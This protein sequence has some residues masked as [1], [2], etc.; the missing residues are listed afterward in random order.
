MASLKDYALKAFINTVDH[1]GSMSYKV[2]CLLNEKS[3]E[4]SSIEL[5]FSCFEQVV[6][7][8]NFQFH[9]L[10]LVVCLLSILVFLI[11]ET[12]KLKPKGDMLSV[13]AQ[14]TH[15]YFSLGGSET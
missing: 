10:L 15:T 13:E 4:F 12:E 9:N 6:L 8:L 5:P 7:D 14:K 11:T 2:N 3:D 1:L